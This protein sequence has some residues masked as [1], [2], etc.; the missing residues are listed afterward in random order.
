MCLHVPIGSNFLLPI[1]GI[2]HAVCTYRYLQRVRYFD[3]PKPPSSTLSVILY[4]RVL[5]IE[6]AGSQIT[7][8][9]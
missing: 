4:S 6:L 3:C 9:Q 5:D 1:L 8:I 2:L 7:L